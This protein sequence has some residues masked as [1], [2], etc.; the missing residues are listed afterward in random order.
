[1]LQEFN[2][3]NMTPQTLLRWRSFCSLVLCSTQ[4]TDQI[5]TFTQ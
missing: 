5:C 2:S 3:L 1:M 4:C